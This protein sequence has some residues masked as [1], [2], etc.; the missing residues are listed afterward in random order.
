VAGDYKKEASGL[1]DLLIAP[2][3]DQ[4][5]DKKAICII[6]NGKLSNIPFQALGKLDQEKR[7]RF[8]VEDYRVFYTNKMDVFMKPHKQQ[9]INNSFVAFGNPD[10]SLDYATAEVKNLLKIM[11][12]GSSYIEELATEDV[13]KTSF[14]NFRY[15]H[16]ATHGVLNYENYDSSY[17]LFA[18]NK[19]HINEDGKAEDGMLTIKEING[20]SIQDCDLVTLSACQTAVQKESV[21][22]WYISPA[23]AFLQRKVKSV[24]ASLWLINDEATSILMDEFYKNLQYMSKVEALRTAQETLSKNPKYS[25]PHYW[26]AFVLY[27]DWR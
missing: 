6:P 23:N 24:V 26:G 19:S 5:K 18:V 10:K 1:Y 4:L 16:L 7:F 17:L 27:G 25:H 3:E 8:L 14:K 13:A 11:T 2:I 15:I 12:K 22:G 9:Q 20:L 21:K